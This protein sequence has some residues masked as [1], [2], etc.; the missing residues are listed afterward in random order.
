MMHLEL[1]RGLCAIV[2]NKDHARL[3][4]Y[5]WFANVRPHTTYAYRTVSV[6]GRNKNI[7]LHREI[8]EAP[9]GLDVD[10]ITN[11]ERLAKP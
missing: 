11:A 10:H 6:D 4:A 1:T 3:S 9:V 8:V 5:R 2:D 7:Q